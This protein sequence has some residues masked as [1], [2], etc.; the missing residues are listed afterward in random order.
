[1]LQ[2][3]HFLPPHGSEHDSPA[4]GPRWP[5]LLTTLAELGHGKLP[6]LE[7]TNASSLQ[8]SQHRG[9][10]LGNIGLTVLIKVAD[11]GEFGTDRSQ[12]WLFA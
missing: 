7:F 9:D 1:L 6:S 12:G 8:L 2:A 4:V 3:T 5:F 11:F 10:A